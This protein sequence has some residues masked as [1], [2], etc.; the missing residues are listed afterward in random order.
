MKHFEF[1]HIVLYINKFKVIFF[2]MPFFFKKAIKLKWKHKAQICRFKE[3]LWN[4]NGRNLFKTKW[5]LKKYL[6]LING[7]F[8]DKLIKNN[9]MSLIKKKR[10]I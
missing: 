5:N 8:I 6:S 3:N 10:S 7:V 9:I 1:K 2:K 4:L